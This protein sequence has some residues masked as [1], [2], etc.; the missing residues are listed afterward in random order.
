MRGDGGK[1]GRGS[2]NRSEIGV[3]V[4]E[5][6]LWF[7]EPSY[8]PTLYGN[9]LLEHRELGSINKELVSSI[10]CFLNNLS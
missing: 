2:G 4:K 8:V 10:S 6:V 9:C 1:R 7:N 3:K 5:G